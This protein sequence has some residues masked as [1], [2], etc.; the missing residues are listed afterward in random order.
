MM[1]FMVDWQDSYLISKNKT[2]LGLGF[3]R[4]NL[5]RNNQ[6]I[7]DYA[8]ANGINYFETCYFYL[9]HQCEDFVY[10]LLKKHNRQEYEICGK[11]SLVE[12]F[13]NRNNNEYKDIYY[14]QLRKVPGNYFDVFLLQGFQPSAYYQIFGTDMIEFFQKEKEKGNI[15]RFG[16][17]EQCAHDL[18]SKFLTLDCWDIAQM[19]LNYYDWFLCDSDE[20]YRLIKEKNIPIIAQAPFK[21]GEIV[22]NLFPEMEELLKK[23][24]GKTPLQTALDFVNDKEPEIILT[25]CSQLSTLME[26]EKAHKNYTSLISYDPII[27]ALDIYKKK[28]FIPCLLCERCQEVCPVNIKLPLFIAMYNKTLQNKESYFESLSLIKHFE[29]EPINNCTW[30][31]CC[32]N[33][34]PLRLDIPSK[35]KDI[36]ELRP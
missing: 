22:K 36:F 26:V 18:L 8:L 11:L 12:C 17:A 27:N 30:C 5:S 33:V 15:L 19:P 3:M 13:L 7:I 29:K 32:V 35:L 16:F 14:S 24:Y 20:N 2:K 4:Y 6:E 31:G 21:G 1:K 9:D 25:G 23:E 34:C 28:K 10:S